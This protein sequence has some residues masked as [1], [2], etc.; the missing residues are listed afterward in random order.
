MED[1]EVHKVVELEV[2]VAVQELEV[3]LVD[4]VEQVVELELVDTV[5]QV[6]KLELVVLV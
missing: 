3:E 4:T 6:A 1:L 2:L 5:E